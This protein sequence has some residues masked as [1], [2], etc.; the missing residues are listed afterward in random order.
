MAGQT[1]DE[2]GMAWESREKMY[3]VTARRE[4]SA[5]PRRREA[6]ASALALAPGHLC[7]SQR[8][9]PFARGLGGSQAA[10]LHCSSD[11]G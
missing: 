6:S 2:E 7:L 5:Y 8:Q 4:N 11:A 10:A 1:R 3:A 9:C